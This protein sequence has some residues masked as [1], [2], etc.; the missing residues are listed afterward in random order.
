MRKACVKPVGVSWIM[1][2]VILRSI[3]SQQPK[4]HPTRITSGFLHVF[5]LLCAHALH[6]KMLQFSRGVMS[7]L[8]TIHTAYMYKNNLLNE[9]LCNKAMWKKRRYTI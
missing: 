6:K 8:H 9:Y 3:H 7:V 1:A 5:Y 4:Q 2:V